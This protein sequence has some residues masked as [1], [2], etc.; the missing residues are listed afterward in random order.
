MTNALPRKKFVAP[1]LERH[2]D[3]GFAKRWIV[4][5]PITH[6]ILGVHLDGSS[7]KG[8]VRPSWFASEMFGMFALTTM[9]GGPLGI[10]SVYDPKSVDILERS[11]QTVALPR[12]SAI[13]TLDDL[14]TF[15]SD[16]AFWVPINVHPY[17]YAFIEA[18]RGN[19]ESARLAAEIALGKRE[20]A[21]FRRFPVMASLMLEKLYA[22]LIAD[23]PAGIAS[24]FHESEAAMVE[25]WGLT[26]MWQPTPFPLELIGS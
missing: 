13:N 1:L 10:L 8:C 23:D 6:V 15:G 3:W 24:M 26:R 12:L 4:F 7:S 21:A 18:A 22:L 14:V 9:L 11:I 25:Q 19:L 16:P 17:R 20:D 2:P 5:K